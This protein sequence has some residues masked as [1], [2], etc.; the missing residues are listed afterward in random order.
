[1]TAN[2][3]HTAT[4]AHLMVSVGVNLFVTLRAFVLVVHE[5]E[6]QA[7]SRGNSGTLNRINEGLRWMG[8]LR[9]ANHRHE[10]D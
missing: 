6:P 4:T 7:N 1:M 10:E 9:L 5:E 3:I 8:G 2:P